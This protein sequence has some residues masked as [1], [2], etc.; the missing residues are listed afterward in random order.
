MKAVVLGAGVIGITTAYYLAR[1][2]FQVVVLD[3]QAEAAA[4]TSHA[5][6]GLITPGHSFTWNSPRAPRQ[7]WRSLWRDDTAYR[8]HFSRDPRFWSWGLKFLRECAP[9]RSRYS[10][11]VK[12]RLNRFS[13][14]RIEEIAQAEALEFH[15]RKTGIL[16]FYRGKA[17]FDEGIGSMR[18]M[19]EAGHEIEFVDAK[20]AVEIEP[21]LRPI[22]GEIA[23]AVYCPTDASGDCRRFTL[24]LTQICRRLGV[25]FRF[26]ATIRRLES[27]GGRVTGV[28]TDSGPV[29]GDAYVLALGSYSP[30][31]ASALGL[32]IPVYPVKGFSLTLPFSDPSLSPQVGGVDDGSLVAYCGMGDRL[33]L[34]ATADFSGYDRS[35]RPGDFAVMLKVAREMFPRGVDFAN[36]FYWACLRPMTPDG[37]PIIGA[38]PVPNLWLNTGHGHMGWTMSAGSSRILADLMAGRAASHPSE[39]LAFERY[40]RKSRPN[41]GTAAA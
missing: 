18:M 36:P 28:A 15:F 20:R 33:R 32:D 21:A 10:T 27:A 6:A 23:G 8:M 34:T 41:P 38:S 17:E 1:E 19:Q 3:R 5:N 13:Q 26:G 40:S 31:I 30:L 7:L 2:G 24:G 11:L 4:E 22:E 12:Y 29:S 37:P 14:A 16:V 35:H 9:A 25:E 39:A